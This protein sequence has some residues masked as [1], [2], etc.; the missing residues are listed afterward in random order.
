MVQCTK[1]R[2][3]ARR[4][5][6]GAD[7]ELRLAARQATAIAAELKDKLANNVVCAAARGSGAGGGEERRVMKAA[8]ERASESASTTRDVVDRLGVLTT[9]ARTRESRPDL[10]DAAGLT[11]PLRERD[12]RAAPGRVLAPAAERAAGV[13]AAGELSSTEH[14]RETTPRGA[15]RP[16]A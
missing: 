4:A 12:G 11:P 9:L 1:G 13:L 7:S 3:T 6:G 2:C 8:E 5:Q 10:V 15:D 14:G 16:L